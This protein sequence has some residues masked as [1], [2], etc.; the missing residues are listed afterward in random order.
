MP[1]SKCLGQDRVP[2]HIITGFLGVGKTTA[3]LN[4]LERLGGKEQVQLIASG[5]A[6]GKIQI[7]GDAMNACRR[8]DP[9]VKNKNEVHTLKENQV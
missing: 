7:L 9:G 8:K 2:F 4:L 5:K 6:S 1:S 3:I